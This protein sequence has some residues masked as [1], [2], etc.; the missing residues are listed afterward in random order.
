MDKES[1][2][3]VIH[4][5]YGKRLS[6]CSHLLFGQWL[7]S[8][9]EKKKK[10]E[11]LEQIWIETPSVCTSR[12]EEKWEDLQY[13]LQQPVAEKKVYS[14]HRWIK[15]VAVLL[16]MIAS[17]AVVYFV[18]QIGDRK[19]MVWKEFFVPYGEN[20]SIQLPDGTN[21]SVEAGS[22]LVYPD[23]F[24]GNERPVF[25]SGE[26]SFTVT[27]DKKKPFVVK[28]QHLNVEVL[29]TVFTINSYPDVSF[30]S[31]TLEKGSLGV[32]IK[33]VSPDRTIL[34]PSEQLVFSH[35]DQTVSV[36]SIDMELYRM[37][38]KGFLIFRDTPFD[39]LITTLE[40]KYNVTIHYDSRKY[41]N[42]KCNLKFTPDETIEEVMK[43]LDRLLHI[44][45]KIEGQIIYIN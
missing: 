21:V 12:T 23:K 38:R 45:Y 40:R 3:K 10:E 5:F 20:Q 29:G 18:D 4:S 16:L 7:C 37:E 25:L 36:H 6:G 9:G 19:A 17:G 27:P 34:K 43:V 26:A 24:I 33:D 22:L 30:T 35:K 44:K 2:N 11:A 1:V 41:E 28:T 42:S 15:Y 8:D 32:N 14:M 13:R 31:V 39:Q